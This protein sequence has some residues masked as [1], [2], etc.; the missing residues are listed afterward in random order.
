MDFLDNKT[1]KLLEKRASVWSEYENSQ[2]YS[3]QLKETVLQTQNNTKR[4]PT[5]P[6]NLPK[7][8]KDETNHLLNNLTSL[9]KEITSANTCKS[10]IQSHKAEIEELNKKIQIFYIAIGIVIALLMFFII[11]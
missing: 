1:K 9:Q 6:S 7:S 2:V 11:S 10:D 3:K 8:V 5:S 4:L